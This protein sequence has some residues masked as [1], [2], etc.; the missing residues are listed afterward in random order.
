MKNWG[1]ILALT[2][3][4]EDLVISLAYLFQGNYRMTLYWFF[5][6]GITATV[7]W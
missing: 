6:S 3:A 1:R 2:M 5:A 7:A 4:G